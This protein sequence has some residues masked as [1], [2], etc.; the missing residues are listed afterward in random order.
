MP[1]AE[2]DMANA[3]FVLRQRA[4]GGVSAPAALWR[5]SFILR[6]C[7]APLICVFLMAADVASVM[8]ATA[9]VSAIGGHW[10]GP[11]GPPV[12][13]ALFF[14]TL[15]FALGLYAVPGPSF[16]ARFRLRTIASFG[17]VGL[18][19][20]VSAHAGEKLPI[21]SAIGEAVALVIVG[22]YAETA[23]RAVLMRSGLWAVAAVV[24]NCDERGRKIAS[25]LLRHPEIGISPVG[26]LADP[27]THED[28]AGAPDRTLPIL[29]AIPRLGELDIPIVVFTSRDDMERAV[30]REELRVALP[31]VLLV[32]NT[33]ALGV[34]GLRPR[35]LGDA[36][37]FEVCCDHGHPGRE[38]LKRAID[39]CLA[40]PL[41]M[42][43]TPI[44]AALAGLIGLMS[45]GAS[46]YTQERVG[47]HGKSIRVVKLRT[48]YADAE[49]RLEAYLAQNPGARDEWQRFFKLKQDPRILP[50]VGNFVRRC[51]LD[52]LPQFWNVIRGDMSLVG[53]RPFPAYHVRAFDVEFQE[54][55]A[56]IKPGLTGLW[57][58]SARSNGDIDV[59]KAQDSFYIN[60]WSLWLD[61]YILVQTLPA[62]LCGSGAR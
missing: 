30:S 54:L 6:R 17:A 49:S 29:G 43:A 32:E 16:L 60:N 53:P 14:V 62:V 47:R 34:L 57:Q 22:Q 55:R 27:G 25:L 11:H 50:L 21:L 9:C 37:G 4:A 8:G 2:F 42:V 5:T 52:E 15:A 10:Y 24:V 19:L 59:Q 44:I 33:T 26:Y 7:R 51:S 41:A 38:V 39:L 58:I 13:T 61:F 20:L 31:R 12:T 45:P 1:T 28:A 46:F 40:V 48:M 23:L 18:D 35:M 36:V 3:G 56:S